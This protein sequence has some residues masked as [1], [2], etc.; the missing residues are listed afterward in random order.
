MGLQR[1]SLVLLLAL[2]F[3]SC[4]NDDDNDIVSVP[5][6][7]LSEQAPKDDLVIRKYLETHFYNYEAFADDK[8]PD[9][10]I[11]LDTIAGSNSR[12]IPLI[13]QVTSVKVNVSSSDLGLDDNETDVEH[14]LYYLVAREGIGNTITVADS[15]YLRYVGISL[16]T[17]S[18]LDIMQTNTFD[19]QI[20]VPIWQ[21][22]PSTIRGYSVGVS[23]IRAGGKPTANTDGTFSVPEIGTGVVFMPSGLAYFNSSPSGSGIPA[24]SPLIFKVEAVASVLDTDHDQ[25][26]IPS[27]EE[28]L[29]KNNYL[30]DDNTDET[31]EDARNSIRFANF[32]DSDD[33]DDGIL[34]KDEII[35]NSD[36]SIGFPDTD[37]DG[38][39]DYLDD[40]SSPQDNG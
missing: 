16:D 26:G 34:T 24:Y 4:N 28:D 13:D 25:D 17:I 22:L 38:V 36:G 32:I 5:P 21:S 1:I 3:F 20:N 29:N 37:G 33:D 23:K 40:D 8:D 19:A 39:P 7:L 30:Y 9:L 2:L 35:L 11:E 31:S 10:R 14:T 18:S 6:R 12:K 27:I 15:V